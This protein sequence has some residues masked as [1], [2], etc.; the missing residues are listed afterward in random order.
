[1]MVMCILLNCSTI[2]GSRDEGKKLKMQTGA[3]AGQAR[4]S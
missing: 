1:M 3:N 4:P 2:E